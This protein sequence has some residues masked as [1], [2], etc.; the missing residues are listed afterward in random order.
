MK[1]TIMVVTV[2]ITAC[3]G[4]PQTLPA[5]K[6]TQ[7]VRAGEYGGYG[8]VMTPRGEARVYQWGSPTATTV[9]Y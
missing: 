4:L 9:R 7:S 8:G 1:F 3:A 2:M 6:F 5:D